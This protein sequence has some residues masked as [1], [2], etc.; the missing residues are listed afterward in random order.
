MSLMDYAE[1]STTAEYMLVEG[2]TG[3]T[4]CYKLRRV[5]ANGT[6]IDLSQSNYYFCKQLNCLISM[7]RGGLG[8][9]GK[10]LTKDKYQKYNLRQ[11]MR[12]NPSFSRG[13][14][15]DSDEIRVSAL[16]QV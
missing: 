8:T 16:N 11:K 10:S 3:P 7:G 13:F 14:K 2:V 1:F 4:A 9:K 15:A 12:N 6:G 5:V